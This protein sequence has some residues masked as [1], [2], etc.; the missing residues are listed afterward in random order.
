MKWPHLFLKAFGLGAAA[1]LV[2]ALG[3]YE[4]RRGEALMQ[5][6]AEQE[7]TVAAQA[8]FFLDVLHRLNADLQILSRQSELKM[9]EPEALERL[10]E[11]F[12]EFVRATRN[13]QGIRLVDA[14]RVERMRATTDEFGVVHTHVGPALA[15]ADDAR[16]ATALETLT[17]NTMLLT[18]R[19]DISSGHPRP[20][21]RLAVT[22]PDSGTPAR[23]VV[24]V[25]RADTL[26]DRLTRLGRGAE[27]ALI[28]ASRTGVWS[29][30]TA[31]G[32]PG[33]WDYRPLG[34]EP[35]EFARRH[36]GAWEAMARDFGGTVHVGEGFFVFRTL[37]PAIGGFW[38]VDSAGTAT[39]EASE[40][41]VIAFVSPQA[42]AR[43]EGRI[44]DSL[45]PSTIAALLALAL[46]AWVGTL[47]WTSQRH[48][49]ARL[50]RQATTDAL[51]G[52]LNRAAFDEGFRAALDRYAETGGGFAL[53]YVDLDHF[54]S[55]NDRFG[56]EAGDA[57]LKETV[58]RMRA[59]I[60][61]TDLLGRLGGDEFAAVLAP[62]KG[63]AAAEAILDKVR[64]ALADGPPP[65][66]GAERAIAASLGVAL[67]PEDGT[68]AEMLLR[69]ADRGMYGAKRRHAEPQ[70]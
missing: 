57:C 60:R 6:E 11:E 9:T 42:V 3:V 20:L 24:A 47:H 13:Y 65:F 34:A 50:M 59:V 67:C 31:P 52:A 53:I 1:I 19:A 49:H 15:L 43:L 39:P 68:E 35:P 23:H 55:V 66:P 12:G 2:V 64:G 29:I 14:A 5:L 38:G 69:T 62:I 63:R 21:W 70:V 36:P 17:P 41:R 58:R 4:A 32:Q 28:L 46:I 22:A 33:S 7:A 54:K 10:A 45:V 26:F 44:L 27:T 30:S 48:R 18:D 25:Y 56:H 61:E 8:S 40:W 16:L 51:T 37:F